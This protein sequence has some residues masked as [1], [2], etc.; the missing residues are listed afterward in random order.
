MLQTRT[1]HY[2]FTPLTIKLHLILNDTLST[3][4]RSTLTLNIKKKQSPQS[5]NPATLNSASLEV[6]VTGTKPCRYSHSNNH[7]I[8]T[9]QLEISVRH[10]RRPKAH[11]TPKSGPPRLPLRKPLAH[12]PSR[13]LPRFPRG[14]PTWT[15]LFEA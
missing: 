15:P 4:L 10:R 7:L 14:S 8:V 5:N 3:N 1:L 12:A 6:M 11:G 2:R 13:V 9:L